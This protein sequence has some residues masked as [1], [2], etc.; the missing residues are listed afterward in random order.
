MYAPE[1]HQEILTRAR[2][3][4]RINVRRL[5][6]ALEVTPETIRRDLATLERHGVLRRVHG[7]AMPVE[8]TWPSP[9]GT[10]PGDERDASSASRERIARAALAELPATG[11]VILGAGATTVRLAELLPQDRDLTVVTPSLRVA[12]VVATRPGIHLHVLGGRVLG[13][14]PATVG[15]WAARDVDD[16]L[17]D[18][19][20]L[21]VD[22][23]TPDLGLTSAD[24]EEAQVKRC[25]LAAARRTV[26]LAEHGGFGREAS[27]HVAALD[28]VDT[29]ISDTELDSELAE[30]ITAAGPRIE[31]A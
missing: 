8:R 5:A 20:F 27:A 13:R 26:V 1:R 12:L 15:P 2:E 22:G 29:V 14:S 9:A 4:G 3:R 24:P 19:A 23:I 18:V 10:A 16:M 25:L 31:L 21:E 28:A 17:V 7:G 11:A 30:A 6:Q